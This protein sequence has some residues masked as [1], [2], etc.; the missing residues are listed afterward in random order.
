MAN[1]RPATRMSMRAAA[2]STKMPRRYVKPASKARATSM[3]Q[4][5][6][7]KVEKPLWVSTLSMTI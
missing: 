4:L 6:T 2:C 3:P 1:V 7:C 5:R